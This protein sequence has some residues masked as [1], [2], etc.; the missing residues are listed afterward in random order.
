MLIKIACVNN[1]KIYNCDINSNDKV[2]VSRA[3]NSPEP[4]INCNCQSITEKKIL[5]KTFISP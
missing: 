1:N 2:P 4:E 3:R 5:M